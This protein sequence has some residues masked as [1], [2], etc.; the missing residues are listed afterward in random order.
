VLNP[1]RDVAFDLEEKLLRRIHVVVCPCIRSTD[2]GDH[3]IFFAEDGFRAQRALEF[4]GVLRNPFHEIEGRRAADVVGSWLWLRR[5]GS[6]PHAAWVASAPHDQ[7]RKLRPAEWGS[8]ASLRCKS[9]CSGMSAL[10]Q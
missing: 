1:D 8:Q 10:G 2:D 3:E 9:Y 4:I 5:H 6:L 7:I